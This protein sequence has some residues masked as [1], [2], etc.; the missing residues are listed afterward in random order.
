[1]QRFLLQFYIM[2]NW[3]YWFFGLLSLQILLP[4]R[5]VAQGNLLLLPGRVIFEG[6]KRYEELN[7][8]NT[9]KD[10]ARYVIS[11]MHIRMKEDGGF[12]EISQPD[13]GESFA[14]QF[15]RFFPHS[16]VLGPGESQVVKIQLTRINELKPGEYRSHLYFRAIPDKSP[17]G[18]EETVADTGISVRLIPIFGI[19]IPV[20][21]RVGESNTQVKL[22]D[23]SIQ[24][25]EDTIP[26]LGLTFHRTGNMSVYGDISIY[27]TSRNGK[28]IPAGTAKGIAVYTPNQDRRFRMALDKKS[29]IDYHSGRLSVI[30]NTADENHPVRI[31]GADLELR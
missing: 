22:S 7:L 11:L 9:G 31:A 14:D 15:I 2:T 12:E 18:E 21:I 16:V 5:S 28:T 26:T 23:L 29:D 10:T 1:M 3:R 25:L 8:G 6:G 4:G 24:M 30:Y 13:S 27:Y 19:S 17:L 20:I